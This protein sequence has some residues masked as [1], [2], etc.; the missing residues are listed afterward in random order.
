[1]N[2]SPIGAV[3]IPGTD[4]NYAPAIKAGRWVFLTGIEATDYTSG[5]H[6][7][8]AGNEEMPCHGLPRHRREGDYICTR[9]RELLAQAGTSFS[10]TVR[11]DQYYPTWKA[12]DPYH[13]A[14]RA[15]FGDYIPPSTSV[16]VEEIVTRGAAISASLLAVI[17]G[18]GCE[19]K[20]VP[21]PQVTSLS[22][23]GFVPAVTSGDLVFIAGQVARGVDTNP[24]PR[25]HVASHSL[26]GGY[27]IR[28]QT[29]YLIRRNSFRR[30]LLRV[31]RRPTPSRRRCT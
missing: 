25:A 8:V 9:F 13:L 15:A 16:L 23:S 27:E 19:P 17:P 7:L 22:F 1:M 2:V 14:R 28:R 20:R 10:N 29:E 5:L 18:G 24:D 12:V 30:W 4:I 3:L 6:P 21:T 26:W 11:L 31:L